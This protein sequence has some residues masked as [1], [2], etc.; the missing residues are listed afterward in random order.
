MARDFF[1]PGET[2]VRVKGGA[3]LVADGVFP[4]MTDVTQLGLASEEIRISPRFIHKDSNAFSCSFSWDTSRTTTR[5]FSSRLN[6]IS[7]IWWD[8]SIRA[9]LFKGC[10]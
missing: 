9:V 7:M 2:M 3:H 1:L 10:F 5:S 6:S 4:A 8:L